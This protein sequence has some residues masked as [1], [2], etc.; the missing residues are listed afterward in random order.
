MDLVRTENSF[1]RNQNKSP[2]N[3]RGQIIYIVFF[4]I[5][6]VGIEYFLRD[7]FTKLTFLISMRSKSIIV[8]KYLEYLDF[9]NWSG[10]YLFLFFLY[11]FVNVYAALSLIFLDSLSVFINGL[12]RFPYLDPRPFWTR[13]DLPPLLLCYRLRK[14]FNYRN[15]YVHNFNNYLQIANFQLSKCL[16]Q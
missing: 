9:Y 11:N 12:V 13:P 8:C 5:A 6:L 3:K 2:K 7:I 14:S 16:S 4:T 15:K 10:R 1:V